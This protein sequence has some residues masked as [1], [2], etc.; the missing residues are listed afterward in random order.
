MTQR[1]DPLQA[2]AVGSCDP[3]IVETHSALLLALGDRVF[4]VKKPVDLGFLDFSTVEARRAVCRREVELNRRMAPDVYLGVATLQGETGAADEPMV[5][6]RRLPEDRALSAL[7]SAGADVLDD[8]RRV[9]RL[10]AAF[11]TTARRSPEIDAAGS[12]ERIRR[13]WDSG[14]DTL[15]HFVGDGLDAATL[16]RMRRLSGRYLDGRAPLFAERQAAGCIR[17]GHGDLL[18]AD[19]FCLPDGPRVLDCIEFDDQLRYGDVLLDVAFLAMDLE[20]LGH[21]ELAARFLHDYEEFS[22][23]PRSRSLTDHY[24][25]YRAQVRSKV[26][27]LRWAQ[28]D[29][30][31]VQAACRQAALCLHHLEAAAVRLVLVGGLPGTGKST[32][33]AALGDR[34]GWTVMRSDALRKELAGRAWA[35]VERVPFAEGPYSAGPTRRTYDRLLERAGTALERGESVVLDAS[36]AS[37][38]Q[39]AAA[40]A[41]AAAVSADVVELRCSASSAVAAARTAQRAAAGTD[42]S[43]ADAEV[44]RRMA[45]VFDAWPRATVIDTERPLVD[46]T[47]LA[48]AAID[49]R[50]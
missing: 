39:R 31:A 4:K 16:A 28:G 6:M 47:T 35:Q 41:L 19:V 33:S 26:N 17:D 14:L 22:G 23:H 13:L 9:A 12:V 49:A 20:D 43:D 38:Q 29:A 18:A 5:V 40:R 45:Q 46:V 48:A 27:L 7:V 34:Y 50:P 8:L 10:V 11:H 32:L 3:R 24:I 42:P 21:R 1:A 36:W 15:E 30:H 2:S 44:A 37:G 25:A